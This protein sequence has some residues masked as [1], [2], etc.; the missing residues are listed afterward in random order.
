MEIFSRKTLREWVSF[1]KRKYFVSADHSADRKAVLSHTSF[2][3]DFVP[4]LEVNN[5]CENFNSIVAPLKVWTL[6]N[7]IT[8]HVMCHCS[9]FTSKRQTKLLF[10]HDFRVIKSL[11]RWTCVWAYAMVTN[12]TRIQEPRVRYE[13][14]LFRSQ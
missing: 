11:H 5:I 2:N 8:L 1:P 4:K 7:R 3:Y 6:R 12:S 9:T 14:I 13:R 10:L